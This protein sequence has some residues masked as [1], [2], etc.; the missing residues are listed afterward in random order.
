M[1]RGRLVWLG[2]L[3][4]FLGEAR[5]VS[6]DGSVVVGWAYNASGDKRAFRWTASGGMQDLGTLGGYEGEALSVSADG[7]AVVGRAKNA[8][9]DWHAF[10]WTAESRMEDLG[11]LGG[12]ESWALGVSA[13][14]SVVVG[15]AKNA[16]GEWC[17]FRWTAA[18]GMENLWENLWSDF[19]PRVAIGVSVDGSVKL[20]LDIWGI[21][22]LL[23]LHRTAATGM[24]AL[25]LAMAMLVPST[26]PSVMSA[27]G[28]VVVGN[29]FN[30][31]GHLR[32]FRRTVAY[33]LQDRLQDMIQQLI[34]AGRPQ[35]QDLGTLG[36]DW[37]AAYGVSADGSVVVGWAENKSGYGRA[38]RWTA[39]GGMED[40]NETYAS[41]LTNGSKLL[42]AYAISPD[43]RYIV[44]KG[45]NAATRRH[46][47]FLLDT[48]GTSSTG[49]DDATGL[50]LTVVPQPVVGSGFVHVR[51]RGSVRVEVCDLL[52]RTLAV[53]AEG[54]L[55]AGGERLSLPQL[56]AG[57]YIVRARS[58]QRWI[59]SAIVVDASVNLLRDA[60]CSTSEPGGSP[61]VQR[62]QLWLGTLGGDASEAYGVSADGSVVV[63]R[64]KNASAHG[65]AF[66]WTA[67]KGMYALGGS[68]SE[69]SGMSADGSVVVGWAENA[70][71][72]QC[73][74]RWTVLGGMQDLGT[75]GGSGSA[76]YGVSADGSVVV[77][78]AKNA[79]GRLRAFRWTK[80]GRIHDLG[81]LGGS[82]SAAY[83][84]SAD[85]SLVVGWAENAR[86]YRR[87]FRW[88]AAG[89]MQ[90]LGTLGGD[91]SVA[92]SVSADGSVVVGWAENASG[93]RHAFRWTASGGMQDL[94]TLGGD[95]SV[96]FGVS[97][98]G[99]V[100]VGRAK[101]ASGQ[102]RAFR[103][104]IASGMEDLNETYASLLTDGSRLLAARAISPDGR[105]IVGQGYN[106][107]TGR[108]EAFLLDTRGTRY[109]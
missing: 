86:S 4:G 62:R 8:R 66:R 73:A 25:L 48:Q 72:N 50:E 69:A 101:D 40:L 27:D 85:G 58:G 28:S 16:S 44:G 52:G 97:A 17:T 103:W 7:S 84:V 24:Y 90:D 11:T 89:G 63:G 77:G 105:Y 2:T 82:G 30:E 12:D 81:T 104:T 91:W 36:G 51:A 49:E 33:R 92:C 34:A 20:E 37:S 78:W 10:R 80:V 45:Y 56:P 26:Q 6:A 53:L 18:G 9:G 42:A 70:R 43:G 87:A 107:A 32:A 47:A 21:D 79:S 98:D 3:G 95:E 88:T 15:W 108:T 61:T 102:W 57:I 23:S 22:S 13:D 29:V 71:G 76:A 65:R 109:R 74:F 35:L 54:M 55:P 59:T 93:D 31:S 96:A 46:E 64:A 67:A 68:E 19:P 1:V 39:S 100:V 41:L 83:G 14:G 38:F 60:D 5:G 99:S 106:A 75:L 94:G